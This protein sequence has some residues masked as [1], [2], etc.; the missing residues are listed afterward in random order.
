MVN[1]LRAAALAAR[2]A[3][4]IRHLGRRSAVLWLLRASQAAP[5]VDYRAG[6]W[7]MLQKSSRATA[8]TGALPGRAEND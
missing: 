4:E 5:F 1:R 6:I 3:G 7:H 8:M 2:E